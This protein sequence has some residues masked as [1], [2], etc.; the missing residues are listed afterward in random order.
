MAKDNKAPIIIKK[1]KKGAHGSHGGAWKVAYA[2]MVTA[3]M[4]FF[5][6]M[7]ICNLDV[8]TRLGIAEYFTQLSVYGPYQP[9]S[10]YTVKSGGVPRLT[11]GNLEQSKSEGGD[12]SSTGLMRVDPLPTDN[13]D[14]EVAK[15]YAKTLAAAMEKDRSFAEL[16]DWVL[17]EVGKEGLR[18]EFMESKRPRFFSPG[19]AS[20]TGEGKRLV[21]FAASVLGRVRHLQSF[22]GHTT[23]APQT[24]GMETKWELG[25]DRALALRQVF[26][27]A[28]LALDL[29]KEVRSYGDTKPRIT[30]DKEDLRNLRV[31][32]Y[33]PYSKGTLKPS[34][35]LQ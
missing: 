25:S 18:M 28:G 32:V 27:D 34:D 13:F 12:P 26:C 9:A 23:P 5:L 10:W 29:V 31:G 15:L 11:Q 33:I 3:M 6:V 17:I 1:I 20:W 21:E 22:E 7:W 16:K 8:K 24:R 35:F 14:L 2:D 30:E 4:A 19:S